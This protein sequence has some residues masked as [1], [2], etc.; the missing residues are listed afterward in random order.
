MF[1]TRESYEKKSARVGSLV[2]HVTYSLGETENKTTLADT[3]YIGVYGYTYSSYSILVT[4]NRTRHDAIDH[5]K[6]SSVMLY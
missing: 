1:P 3:Y 6:S 2:D 5:Q 4:V